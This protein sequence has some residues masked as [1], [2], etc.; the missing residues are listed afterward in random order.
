MPA[1]ALRQ[2]D[3]PDEFVDSYILGHGSGQA[4][5]LSFVSHA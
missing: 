3:Y 4:R 2:E 1:E 5:H